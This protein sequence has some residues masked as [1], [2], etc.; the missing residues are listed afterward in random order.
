MNKNLGILYRVVKDSTWFIITMI[1]NIPDTRIDEYV[2]FPVDQCKS[3]GE[4]SECKICKEC[5]SITL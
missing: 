2:Y 1:A 4:A 3:K 5:L